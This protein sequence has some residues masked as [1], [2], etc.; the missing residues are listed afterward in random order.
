MKTSF[1]DFTSKD[2]SEE[3]CGPPPRRTADYNVLQMM[4]VKV[5]KMSL[6]AVVARAAAGASVSIRA[7][8]LVEG[9]DL[10]RGKIRIL[11][12][13]RS[14]GVIESEFLLRLEE[15]LGLQRL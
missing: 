13:R 10:R 9:L 8:I 4:Q 6:E 3:V 11:T 12:D 14:S 7:R 1:V 2:F 15:T 5:G